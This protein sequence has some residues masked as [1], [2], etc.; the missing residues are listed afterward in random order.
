M[1]ELMSQW[2]IRHRAS[3]RRADRRYAHV[4]AASLKNSALTPKPKKPVFLAVVTGVHRVLVDADSTQAAAERVWS[5]FAGDL[6]TEYRIEGPFDPQA[7][8]CRD[9]VSL[10]YYQN[11]MA[12][13]IFAVDL[14]RNWKE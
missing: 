14:A 8:I 11:A 3:L 4:V 12:L 13:H 10:E 6:D 1:S 5:A 9:A 2:E 7:L